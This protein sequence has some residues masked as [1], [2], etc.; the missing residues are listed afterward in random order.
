ML[1]LSGVSAAGG[2][3]LRY[4]CP[5]GFPAVG[6]GGQFQA[7]AGNVDGHLLGHGVV[8]VGADDTGEQVEN[9]VSVRPRSVSSAGVVGVLNEQMPCQVRR[10]GVAKT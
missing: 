6:Q 3:V 4:R 5:Q 10:I 7:R 2:S 8:D 1:S 9:L